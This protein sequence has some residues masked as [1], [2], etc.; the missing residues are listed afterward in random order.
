MKKLG[1]AISKVIV[2]EYGEEEFLKRISNPYFFQS[3]G[4]IMGFDWHS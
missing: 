2:Y 3:W 4:C 1:G